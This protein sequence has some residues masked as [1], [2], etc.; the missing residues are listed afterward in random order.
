[1][2]CSLRRNLVSEHHRDNHGLF[3]GSLFGIG[4]KMRPAFF[5][6][7]SEYVLCFIRVLV[8]GADGGD[9]A[10]ALDK[11]DVFL[12]ESI[13]SALQGDQAEHRERASGAVGAISHFVG[14]NSLL[15]RAKN[16]L[17]LRSSAFL[18][19]SQIACAC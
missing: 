11:V 16:W 18:S 15:F 13:S 1:M 3:D 12:T 5:R 8:F 19:R 6:R 10:Y 9:S 4:R 14:A 17:G 2:L 7:R